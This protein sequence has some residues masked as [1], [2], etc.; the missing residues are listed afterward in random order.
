VGVVERRVMSG[1][2]MDGA[3]R[4]KHN[5]T[6]GGQVLGSWYYRPLS[7]LSSAGEITA[8]KTEMSVACEMELVFRPGPVRLTIWLST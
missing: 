3:T 1:F 8:T 5:Q 2:V 6:G 4:L 7:M